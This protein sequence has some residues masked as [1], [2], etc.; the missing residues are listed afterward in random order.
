MAACHA[1]PVSSNVVSETVSALNLPSELLSSVTR[2]EDWQSPPLCIC[3][4]ELQGQLC[5]PDWPPSEPSCGV[6]SSCL[7]GTINHARSSRQKGVST[8]LQAVVGIQNKDQVSKGGCCL[9]S[10]LL[11]PSQEA[12]W[13]RVFCPQSAGRDFCPSSWQLQKQLIAALP[14]SSINTY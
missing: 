14:G 12:L 10:A 1:H 7:Q 8:F 3:C 4:A 5:A 2:C 11:N 13:L 6:T 9:P